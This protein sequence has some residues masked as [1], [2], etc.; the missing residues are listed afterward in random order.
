MRENEKKGALLKGSRLIL[1]MSKK[2][3]SLTVCTNGL[4]NV[5]DNK[6]YQNT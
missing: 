1:L 5:E 4:Y 6:N 3:R 2:K